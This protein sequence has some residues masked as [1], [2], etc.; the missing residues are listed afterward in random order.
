MFQNLLYITKLYNLHCLIYIHCK[1]HVIQNVTQLLTTNTLVITPD[2]CWNNTAYPLHAWTLT[3]AT[4]M[5]NTSNPP[6]V[7][8]VSSHPK[9]KFVN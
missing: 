1:N 5:T 3:V 8:C 7:G 9:I 2:T 6:I 4:T